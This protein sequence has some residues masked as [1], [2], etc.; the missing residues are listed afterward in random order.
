[1]ASPTDAGATDPGDRSA[2]PAPTTRDDQRNEPFETPSRE[3]IVA[4]TKPL[5]AAME[6][7]T[8]ERT[9]TAAGMHYVLVAARGRKTGEIR[10]TPLP[11]WRDDDGHRIVIA[12][13]AGAE[14][15]PAWYHNLADKAAN[16]TI[17][18]QD[19]D[20]V[21]WSDVEVLDGD[22]YARVW[23]GI[24]IDRPFYLDYQAM[25]TRRIPLLRL[26]EPDTD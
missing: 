17:R 25:V 19:R 11:Y 3:D 21:Y 7:S 2:R 22:D 16:P 23:A 13:F 24:T 1:M 6:K 9:W 5:V 20:H 10:K 4:M 8:S 12:S 18:V 26:R 15:H 14:H